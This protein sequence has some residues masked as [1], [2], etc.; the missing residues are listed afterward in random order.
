[1]IVLFVAFVLIYAILRGWRHVSPSPSNAFLGALAGVGTWIV[2]TTPVLS[3]CN[4]LTTAGV[5]VAWLVFFSILAVASYK[6]NHQGLRILQGD[7]QRGWRQATRYLWF[8]APCSL[9]FGGTFASALLYPVRLSDGL[10]ALMPRLVMWTQQANL[11]FFSASSSAQLFVYPFTSFVLLH[12]KLLFFGNDFFANGAQWPSYVLSV[13]FVV[14]I[15]RE[16]GSNASGALTAGLA[17]LFTPMAILQAT[18]VQYDLT[19]ACL[20]LAA[21]LIG[22]RLVHALNAGSEVIVW[23]LA[24]LL[25]LTCG[26]G[27]NSKITFG[28]MFVP[29]AL[30]LF[31]AGIRA[32]RWSRT[33]KLMSCSLLLMVLLMVP[34]FGHVAA[35]TGGNPLAVN[36]PGY[37]HVLVPDKSPRM[38]AT[39][40]ARAILLE[41]GTPVASLNERMTQGFMSLFH[42]IGIDLNTPINKEN[43]EDGADW[44]LGNAITNP[45]SAPSPLPMT[46]GM[47]SCIFA[48]FLAL[49]KHYWLLLGYSVSCIAGLFM[50]AGLVTWQIW[51]VRT[52]LG[53]LLLMLPLAGV[54]ITYGK[55]WFA[56]ALR[57][58]VI[59]AGILALFTL[60]WNA[61]S[62][63]V[64]QKYRPF[65]PGESLGYWNASRNDLFFAYSTP[66]L[67]QFMPFI[68]K[69][70]DGLG[71]TPRAVLMGD[72][73]WLYPTY[74]FMRSY[75]H[76]VWKVSPDYRTAQPSE[77]LANEA[78][79][80]I[81]ISRKKPNSNTVDPALYKSVYDDAH[82][83]WVTIYSTASSL[84]TSPMTRTR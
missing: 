27:I 7:L 23:Y 62:P 48:I 61:T 53:P 44:E 39:N 68:G 57:G 45:D 73:L 9:F 41:F 19:T 2:C 8:S 21:F 47:I 66:R 50:I 30:V 37:D 15:A 38:L 42:A 80:V 63:L 35:H 5:W 77:A 14:L 65:A 52:L 59:C 25:G 26:I 78:D 49:R 84:T 75:P 46:L 13:I 74:L 82:E 71:A 18:N 31:V 24:I 43:G 58:L 54:A 34:W 64:S 69:A 83:T 70:T 4:G 11:D 60:L 72:A 51:I 3:L 22:L 28:M 33:M 36:A 32:A 16:L 20:T 79:I 40:A 29:F 81:F 76:I 56:L 1:M 12:Q 55:R 10:A 67:Q 6:Q 17:A